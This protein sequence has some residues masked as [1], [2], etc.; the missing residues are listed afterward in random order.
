MHDG[1]Q[2]RIL[3]KIH[4]VEFARLCQLWEDRG[5][6]TVG[7]TP[8][9]EDL[10]QGLVG[11]MLGEMFLLILLGEGQFEILEV[12]HS[13]RFICKR[14]DHFFTFPHFSRTY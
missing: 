10:V 12:T 14:P 7:Y 4:S 6:G 9:L 2:V 1:L 5:E 3:T 8:W 11:V 13:R